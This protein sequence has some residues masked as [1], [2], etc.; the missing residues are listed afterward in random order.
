MDN[1][2]GRDHS[3]PLEHPDLRTWLNLELRESLDCL[4]YLESAERRV[5]PDWMDLPETT[6]LLVCLEDLDKT[7]SPEL[8]V[9]QERKEWLDCLDSLDLMDNL[10]VIFDSFSDYKNGI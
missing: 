8:L 9:S 5:C 3:D 1:P 4:E 10:E 6:G 2:D 7:A